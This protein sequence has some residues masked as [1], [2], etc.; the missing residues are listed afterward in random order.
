MV[1]VQWNIQELF[2]VSSRVTVTYTGVDRLW[3]GD[4]PPRTGDMV[5]EGVPRGTSCH[6]VTGIVVSPR[7]YK[8]G[9]LGF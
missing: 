4:R 3:E 6:M 8:R 9:S 2:L 5:D 1:T 7:P